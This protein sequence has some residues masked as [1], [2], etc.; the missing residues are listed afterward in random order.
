M[1]SWLICFC[2]IGFL[3]F[4]LRAGAD[5]C[6]DENNFIYQQLS[7]SCSS[8]SCATTGYTCQGVN[9]VIQPYMGI[10]YFST[11]FTG[12]LSPYP[13]NVGYATN[14]RT[15]SQ[16]NGRSIAK[17]K[18]MT[19]ILRP[20]IACG[21]VVRV[22]EQV[23]GERVPL[24]GTSFDLMYSSTFVLGRKSVYR[25][26]IDLSGSTINTDITSF[27]V[28][29]QADGLPIAT[30]SIPNT[31][32]NYSLPIAWDGKDALGA[33]IQGS[34]RFS[35]EVTENHTLFPVTI[36][37]KLYLGSF[38]SK[39]LGLGGW[40]PSIMKFYDIG[41]ASFVEMDGNITKVVA[42]SFATGQ[43]Y[44]ASRD[45]S[46]IY[47]FDSVSGLHLMTK[48]G[49][50]GAT[51]FTFNY[52]SAG[53]LS[54]ISEPFGRLTLFNRNSGGSLISVTSPK[55]QISNVSLDA[56]GYLASL[57]NPNME[58]YSFSYTP[59]GLLLSFQKPTGFVSNFTYD[60][61]GNLIKDAHSGGYF[62]DLVKTINPSY[63]YQI[64]QVSALGR[65][66]TIKTK[67]TNGTTNTSTS[68]RR[69]LTEPNGLASILEYNLNNGDINV[70]ENAGG[71]TV[72]AGYSGIPRFT[73]M[74][75]YPLS[76]SY[77]DPNAGYNY[78]IQNSY[79]VTLS[80]ASDIF[81]IA[82][83]TYT[84]SKYGYLTKITTSYNP[85]LKLF[86]S[87]SYLG[88]TQ[89]TGI[90][91]YERV[92]S[93]KNGSLDSTNYTYTNEYL[94][95]I[96]QGS[97]TTTLSYDPVSGFL[98]GILDPN[99]QSYLFVNDDTGRV[100]S[101]ILP[102]SRVIGYGYDANG[103]LT[104]ITPPGRPAHLMSINSHEMIGSYVP[105]ALS[106]IPNVATSYTY[107]LDKQLTQISRPDG[108]SI[109]YNYNAATG[110]M[111]SFST[112]EG[113]FALSYN[114]LNKKASAVTA[115]NGNIT[116][117]TYAGWVLRGTKSYNPS[118]S[119]QD[120]YRRLWS[121][122]G[123]ITSDEVISE[124]GTSSVSYVYDADER[125]KQ[126]G[127]MVLT[128]DVPN[129]LLTEASIGSGVQQVKDLYTYNNYGEIIAYQVE[130][131]TTVLYSLLLGRDASGRIVSKT[132]SM[133]GVTEAFA[134]DMDSTGRL[135]EVQKNSSVISSYLYD[136]NSNRNGGFVG[137]QP[138]SATYNN[139][140]RL[141]TYNTLSFSYN[142][143]GDLVGKTNNTLGQSTSY[144]Y[145]V[146]GN[147]K[148]VVLMN[149]DVVQYEVDAL[150]RRIGK[151]V[152]GVLQKRWIYMDQYRI[153]AELTA[154]G[155]VSKRFVYGSKGNIP[156][157]FIS[158]GESYRII[159]DQLG[160]PRLVIKISDGTVMH[161]MRHDE[162]GRVVEDTNPG[163]LPFGFAGG[164]YDPETGLVRFGARDYDP[165]IGRWTSKD[166][167]LFG[168]GDTNLYGYV[169][170][171]P[172]NWVDP[173]GLKIAYGD[174]QS[175]ALLQPLIEQ[176][177]QSPAGAALVNQLESSSATYTLNAVS[178]GPSSPGNAFRPIVPGA[179]GS[180][181]VDM[182]PNVGIS[183]NRGVQ[184]A[185]PLRILAHELGHLTGTRDNGPGRMNN[186]N[187][188][189]NP[190]MTPIDGLIRTSY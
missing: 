120:T 25:G 107:N 126:A 106:G 24:T 158:G 45:A 170:N 60:S 40:V 101:K 118:T 50:T 61:D 186:V 65:T 97:R 57:V 1:K 46:Q 159:S 23:L 157:Y 81:S 6:D 76:E 43:I 151:K 31:T 173:S 156:D 100:V 138:T 121:T 160:S 95:S 70:W 16:N 183:T 140:D 146:F 71:V 55:G 112:P 177:M 149:A 4:G 110:L 3:F 56:E 9:I 185:S 38:R 84:S 53:R 129:G 33:E 150:N 93:Q 181:N 187:R 133:N 73:Q 42:K 103:N 59:L 77:N 32:P 39:V 36:P 80:N 13:T 125:L 99:S 29:I 83:W 174:S 63:T 90:D 88:R 190:I 74:S 116:E 102:D 67:I 44:V 161:R 64:N 105:P 108:T 41:N 82:S 127:D 172:V 176:L 162:F 68:T 119:R 155:A 178:G 54:S 20:Q 52:D 85:S 131:D 166:P 184:A 92:I 189:E 87:T 49:L 5:Y 145:D 30:H 114:S 28:T 11:T 154:S 47:I 111:N 147:L 130:R 136:V 35:V 128:I 142:A 115:P 124:M 98:T 37:S 79:A 72:T 18:E 14:Y 86:T 91:S 27:D 8:A 163:Y 139:Q 168:G 123:L 152:N 19:A 21:S 122:R 48:T 89:A 104:S 165:E 51:L 135:I 75:S 148:Q 132:E 141:L 143:N 164:L 113:T 167:I 34:K 188:Y 17:K 169:Q 62:F 12:C 109:N 69:E 182:C 94:T 10:L 78:S 58:T 96:Q 2:M 153:A 175:R 7:N 134:Y 15:C 22:E 26:Q 117:M 66:K 144:Q 180:V 171:D 179:N 137:A